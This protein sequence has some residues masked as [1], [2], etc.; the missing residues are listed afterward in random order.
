MKKYVLL[1]VLIILSACNSD[2]KSKVENKNIDEIDLQGRWLWV[3]S[4]GGFQGV[5]P[6]A[7]KQKSELEF[8]DNYVSTYTDG[9]LIKKLKFHIAIK[10]SIFGGNKKMIVIDK[11]DLTQVYYADR[12]FIITGNKLTLSEECSDCFI[13]KYEKVN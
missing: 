12:S 10:K 13:S 1:F 6:D 7:L 2:D 11:E 5:T 8:S 3:S 4:T 9:Q